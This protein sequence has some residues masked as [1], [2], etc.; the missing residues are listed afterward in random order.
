MITNPSPCLLGGETA[1]WEQG[2]PYLVAMFHIDHHVRP[3]LLTPKRCFLTD[4]VIWSQV[5]DRY[6]GWGWLVGWGCWLDETDETPTISDPKVPGK[7][8]FTQNQDQKMSPTLNSKTPMKIGRKK[9]TGKWRKIAL[10]VAQGDAPRVFTNKAWYS[11]ATGP[12]TKWKSLIE[13]LIVQTCGNKINTDSHVFEMPQKIFD[14]LPRM[15][16]VPIYK[17]CQMD[18][19]AG[20]FWHLKPNCDKNLLM[21]RLQKSQEDLHEFDGSIIIRSWRNCQDRAANCQTAA[22]NRM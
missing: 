18:K 6:L 9:S 21:S 17:N 19:S 3:Q 15:L 14:W 4:V 22:S 7:P 12:R 1:L 11:K 2:I 8:K 5:M 13:M 16:M 10:W 20:D